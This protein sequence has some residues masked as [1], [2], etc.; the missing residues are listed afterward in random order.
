[1]GLVAFV[2]NGSILPRSSGAADTPMLIASKQPKSSTDRSSIDGAIP[3]MSP[4]TMAVE[5][6]LPHR[7][8]VCGMGIVKGVTLIVGGGFHGK[9]TLLKAVEAGVYNHIPGVQIDGVL[10]VVTRI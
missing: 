1:M 8:V 3:F 4:S 2:E 5:V 7:G 10:V 9:S 6:E